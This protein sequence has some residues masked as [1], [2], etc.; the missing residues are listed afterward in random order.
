M[1]REPARSPSARLFFTTQ[2]FVSHPD[3]ITVRDFAD[4]VLAA[5]RPTS[6][7][8]RLVAQLA[9][10]V[11]SGPSARERAVEVV[12]EWLDE[13]SDKRAQAS[14]RQIERLTNELAEVVG[15]VALDL[16][17]DDF[18]VLRGQTGARPWEATTV[19]AWLSLRFGLL[20]MKKAKG[21]FSV[22]STDQI[23]KAANLLRQAG[24]AK[25]DRRNESLASR[26][27]RP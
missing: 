12:G 5:K 7:D 13:L 27:K 4:R 19:M 15:D 8:M 24:G 26:R 22:S 18:R 21:R 16:D 10:L 17:N 11:R 1:S 3:A 25:K 9:R 2:A 14:N 6:G 23:R 20:G